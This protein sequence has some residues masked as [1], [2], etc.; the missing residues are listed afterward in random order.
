MSMFN[1]KGFKTLLARK[2]DGTIV[3]VPVKIGSTVDLMHQK[4]I[5]KLKKQK[6]KE[7]RAYKQNLKEQKKKI[8]LAERAKINWTRVP[9]R[10]L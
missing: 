7:F 10:Y 4:Q 2:K 1:R 9:E 3:P 6:N 8:P 5:S